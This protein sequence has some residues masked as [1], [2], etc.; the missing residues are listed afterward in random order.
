MIQ[1][2][3]KFKKRIRKVL[4]KNKINENNILVVEKK[5]LLGFRYRRSDDITSANEQ[6]ALNSNIEVIVM[7]TNIFMQNKDGVSF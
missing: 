4:P 3:R 5:P 6:Q 7:G 2:C 1:F